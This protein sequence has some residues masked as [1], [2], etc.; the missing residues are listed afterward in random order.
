MDWTLLLEGVKKKGLDKNGILTMVSGLVELQGTELYATWGEVTCLLDF[1]LVI[2]VG[3]I[4]ALYCSK[5]WLPGRIK[6]V[7]LQGTS[8]QE[9][10][11]K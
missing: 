2:T 6:F 1:G 4:S 10:K 5:I 9:I 8:Q 11:S 3:F 7:Y